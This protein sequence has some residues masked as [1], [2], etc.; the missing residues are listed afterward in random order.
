M[1]LKTLFSTASVHPHHYTKEDIENRN[2]DDPQIHAQNRLMTPLLLDKSIP[3]IPTEEER[4]EFPFRKTNIISETFFLWTTPILRTGYRRTIQPQDLFKIPKGSTYDV[5]RRTTIF[6]DHFNNLKSSAEDKYMKKKGI[7]NTEENRDQLRFNPD[8]EYPKNLVLLALYKT[9]FK[10]YTFAVMCKALGDIAAALNSLQIKALIN[11]VHKK[12]AGEHVGNNGYGM[13]VGIACL[14]FFFGIVYARNFNDAS[15]CGA[16]MKGVLTKVLLDKSFKLNRESRSK[17]PPST[18][19]AYLGNDLSKIDLATNFFP[20]IICMPIGLGITIALLAVNLG[21]AALSGI[22]WFLLIT[23]IIA[24]STRFLMRWRRSINVETD[25]RVKCIKEVLNNIKMIKYYAWEIPFTAMIARLR[26]R[27]MKIMMKVQFFRNLITGV[28]VTLPS[29]SALIGFL[30]MYGQLGGLKNVS[31]IFSSV[32]LFNILTAH[33]AMLPTALT[34]A[35]DAWIAFLRVQVFLLAPEEKPDPNY[36][37]HSIDVTSQTSI[38]ISNGTFDWLVHEN[39]NTLESVDDETVTEHSLSSS[40]EKPSLDTKT[41]HHDLLNIDL[42]IK[43][44]EFIVI[45]G[46]IGSGKTSLLAAINGDMPRLA[47]TI[48]I[49]GSTLLC[50]NPWIQNTT[51][52]DNILFGVDYYRDVYNRVIECCSLTSDFEILPAGDMTEIGERGVNLSGGQKARINLAR[53]VYRAFVMKEYNIVMFDDVLSA[54]DAK[55][56]KHI[57]SECIMGM[58]GNKTRVLATHQLSLIGDA[59]R[60]IYMNGDG[61]IDVGTHEEL[62]SHNE[63][64]RTLM[65]FQMEG[66]EELDEKKHHTNDDDDDDDGDEINEEVVE[67]IRK[68]TTIID[69]EKG[70]LIKAETT[71]SNGI[72]L[73]V[74]ITYL[75]T[76]CGKVGLK[77][78][79]PNLVMA[80]TFT[81]FCMLFT[82]V[83]LSFWS[84]DR[85]TTRTDGFYIGI[86]VMI[87]IMFVM[88]AIWQFCTIIF[89][90]N[91]SSTFLNIKAVDNIMH[92]PMSFFDT[93]PMGRIINRFTKDTDVL[94][95]EIAEQARLCCF[96]FGNMCGIL[97]MCCIFLP[98]FAIAVPFLGVYVCCCFNYYQSTAREVKRIEG[99]SRSLV[100]SSFD[101][102]LQGM[103][104]IK[105]YASSDRFIDKNT[106]LINT[107]NEAYLFT[108]SV[109]RWFAMA[110]HGC[111]ASV[112]II[113]CMLSVSRSYPISAASSGLL[114]SYIVQLSMQLISF[115]K[116]LGQVEQY[117]S[118]I[119]RVCEY[120][121]EL[122]QEAAYVNE[123]EDAKIP[124]NWPADGRIVFKDVSL[125]YR[126]ELPFVLKN[127]NLDIKPGE[128]IGICGR[129]GAGKS[130]IMTALYRL[131]EIADGQMTIDGV[132]IS[133]IGL[134][135]LR[136]HLAIIPQDPV[137]FRGTIRR[138]LDPFGEADDSVLQKAIDLACGTQND[139]KFDLDT[140]VEDDGVNFSLGER[141]VIALCRALIRKSKILILDE[142]TSSVDY[143]TD[144]RIQTTIAEG[145]KHCTILCIAHR[146]KTILNYDRILV[147]DKGECAEFDTPMKLWRQ[148]GIFR[149]MC[150]KSGIEEGDFE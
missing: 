109:Q 120:V 122:P 19:T 75:R 115:S 41:G 116:S 64:F 81:S 142:A 32:T 5:E 140:F 7:S 130:T 2:A 13:A 125:K 111:S 96:G 12:A 67:L 59:D 79:L 17:F 124:E 14:V 25:A 121:T 127:M 137:L 53:T 98:W 150:D 35:S 34:S 39:G 99:T 80:I 16:E 135:Q 133:K 148:N 47:G 74:L 21:G 38:K 37:R 52:K 50:S 90:T 55:V 77:F 42:T 143:E 66:E 94:D 56:G 144:A 65:E 138:N 106:K 123:S 46:S 84:T 57:M 87:T 30:S 113:I 147:M 68:Q 15:F 141:Q 70:R 58:L 82:N 101:E 136:S 134:Y 18:V 110:L 93:T 102:S 103:S 114:V 132:D 119:E 85:F 9:Y 31:N 131:S 91:R 118:S 126:P 139:S 86:Y 24:Y 149:S 33:V 105:L 129:T 128:K 112:N 71:K 49:F 88:C 69:A 117:S 76:G 1:T 72:P 28:A 36:I 27:E 108:V 54:V 51:V 61:T 10:D 146:L 48:D 8:F 11:Y 73:D 20:F 3:P 22:A 97:I 145:F 23:S 4:I 29:V 45:T 104:T 107:M 95:N 44:G 89:I 78:M 43:N 83:W 92:A 6:L 63:G 26:N 40:K 60:I 100:F 62:V